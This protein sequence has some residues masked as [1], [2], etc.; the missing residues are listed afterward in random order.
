RV[1]GAMNGHIP[2]YDTGGHLLAWV[3]SEWCEAHAA[4]LRLVRTRRARAVVRA[5]LRADDAPLLAWL[6]A[7]GRHSNFGEAFLQPLDGGRCWA[8]RGVV[9]SR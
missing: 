2:L 5:Y 3:A 9:G 1:D 6:E 4:H 7:S 8:L